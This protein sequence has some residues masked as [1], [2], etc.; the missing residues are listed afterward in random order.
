MSQRTCPNS[1][2]RGWPATCLQ[3]TQPGVTARIILRLPVV[4]NLCV[5]DAATSMGQACKS[6]KCSFSTRSLV[7]LSFPGRMIILPGKERFTRLLVEKEHFRL[8]H[9][10]PML[11]AASLT[12]RFHT[13]GSRRIIRAVTP[14]C[15]TCKHVAGQPRLQLLGQVLCDM[16]VW[17]V[18]LF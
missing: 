14:G 17:K 7:N 11:V 6:L 15:V 10:C 13:T 4:W 16:F 8:L 18:L 12:Q 3:V 2:R 5:R 9:A 1:C